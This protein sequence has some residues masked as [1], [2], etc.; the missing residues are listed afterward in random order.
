[1]PNGRASVTRVNISVYDSPKKPPERA[2]FSELGAYHALTIGLNNSSTFGYVAG[3]S[4]LFRANQNLDVLFQPL[5]ANP[6]AS[7][8]MIK[9]EVGSQEGGTMV[10]SSQNFDRFLTSKGVQHK[11]VVVPG[12]MHSWVSWRGYFRDF[13]TE[14]FKN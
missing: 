1:M 3:L 11:Y 10:A 12:G 5:L 6:A 14:I 13:M 9:V 2:G 8:K 7:F 4:S